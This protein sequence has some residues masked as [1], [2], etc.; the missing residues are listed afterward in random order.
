[1]NKHQ[2]TMMD[3]LCPQYFQANALRERVTRTILQPE[4]DK[5]EQL[6]AELEQSSRQA[7]AIARGTRAK[8]GMMAEAV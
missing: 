3:V 8:A 6:E 1:M 4:I 2:P 5:F 7:P